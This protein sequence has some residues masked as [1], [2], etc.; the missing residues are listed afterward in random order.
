MR[1]KDRRR[2]YGV[3]T[4]QGAV[5]NG[6]LVL[7]GLN[8]KSYQV[9]NFLRFNRNFNKNHRVNATLGVTYDVRDVEK[10]VYIVTNFDS[11]QLTVRQPFLGS[12]ITTPLAYFA[13]DQKMFSL[14]GRFNYTFINLRLFK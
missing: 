12:N 11:T 5:N 6:M 13:Q 14:L 9:N 2:F 4:F 1:S 3:T 10:S 7:N 8:Q